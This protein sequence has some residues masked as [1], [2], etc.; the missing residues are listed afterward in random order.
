M[1]RIE[2]ST[3]FKRDYRRAKAASR[4]RKLDERPTAILELLVND[5]PFRPRA[6]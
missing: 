4:Y 3:A 5:Q 2:R 1:R 6:L